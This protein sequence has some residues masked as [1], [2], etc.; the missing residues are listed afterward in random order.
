[1]FKFDDQRKSTINKVFVGKF[2]KLYFFIGFMMTY[3][4]QAQFMCKCM[5]KG[6]SPLK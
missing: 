6:D 5:H 2:S 3:R 1:L 4:I